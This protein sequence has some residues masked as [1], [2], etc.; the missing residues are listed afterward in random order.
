VL[1]P[2]FGPGSLARH[3][4][5]ARQAGVQADVCRSDRVGFDIDTPDDLLALVEHSASCRAGQL[6]QLLD[7]QAR[8]TDH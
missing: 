6:V 5:A 1:A 4:A 8:T 2:A 7:L 3:L